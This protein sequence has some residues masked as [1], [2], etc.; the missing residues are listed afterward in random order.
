MEAELKFWKATLHPD[1][2]R[3]HAELPGLLKWLLMPFFILFQR[4]FPLSP[5]DNLER[6]VLSPY[7]G[8][9]PTLSKIR[10]NLSGSSDRCRSPTKIRSFPYQWEF[11]FINCTRLVK[12]FKKK[13]ISAI[14]VSFRRFSSNR[15]PKPYFPLLP[16][17]VGF[18][19]S[20][21]NACSTDK[22]CQ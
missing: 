18:W 12:S 7:V 4:C 8:R 9:R 22:K 19:V 14:L 16:T 13:K 10:K 3:L 17:A 2:T 11:Y 6:S 1:L 20:L 21:Y 15:F 5:F